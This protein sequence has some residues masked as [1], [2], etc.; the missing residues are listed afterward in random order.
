M[1]VL[2]S[3]AAMVEAVRCSSLSS[4]FS[5][6]DIWWHLSTG[7][8]IVQNHTFP[9]SGIFSQ[10]SSAVW[11]ASSWPFDVK[12]ALFYRVLGLKAIPVFLMFFKTGLAII[13]FLIAGG[14]RGNFWP[15]VVLSGVA[16]Y[17]LA[18]VQPGPTYCSII[19]FGLELLLLLGSDRSGNR[20]AL[21]WL[22][23]LFLVWANVDIEFVYGLVVLLVFLGAH[24][25]SAQ[26]QDASPKPAAKSMATITAL[27]F[28]A[29]F[30]TPYFYRPYELFLNSAFSAANRYLPDFHAP[31]FRQPQ[32]YV[33][34]LLAMSAFLVL[35][36][37][38]SRDVFQIVLLAA[39]AMLS[40]YSQRDLWTVILAALA[41]IGNGESGDQ[42]SLPFARSWMSWREATLS[43]AISLALVVL[44]GAFAIPKQKALLTKAAESYPVIAANYIREHHL[45]QPMFNAFEWGGFLT[46]YLPDYPVAI[47]GRTDLYGEDTVVSYSK[48]MSA[49]LRYTDY[50]ALA[51]ARTIVL[52]RSAIMAEALG[53]VP[54]FKL[55]YQ[56]DV[57]V[58][59]TKDEEIVPP[60]Q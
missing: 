30:L 25:V 8:W 19:L 21:Y 24:A 37:R 31:R 22:P 5:N 32:D 17:I 45:P 47:D 53:S 23:G 34:L 58:V 16:Q 54:A 28:A 44:V 51:E 18:G 15:A 35:G 36:L 33:L 7:L 56:D 39:S 11:T 42:E 52:P 2:F 13:T 3:A 55:A 60:H 1:V 40:F 29:S 4:L 49:D 59:L 10:A 38:R 20:R 43:G 57:A 48:M 6:G 9:H 41:V 12:L 14:R 50:P 27:S 46:W 26:S